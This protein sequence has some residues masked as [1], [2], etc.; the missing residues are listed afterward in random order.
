MNY[1]FLVVD[2]TKYNIFHHASVQCVHQTYV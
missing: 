2:K 1:L